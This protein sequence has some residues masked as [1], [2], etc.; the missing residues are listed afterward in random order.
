MRSRLPRPCGDQPRG[1]LE[2]PRDLT[3]RFVTIR[4]GDL[5]CSG[6]PRRPRRTTAWCPRTPT[7]SPRD[8]FTKPFA[9]QRGRCAG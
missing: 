2:I 6:C 3:A 7:D 5:R 9:G 4:S 8:V 1:D